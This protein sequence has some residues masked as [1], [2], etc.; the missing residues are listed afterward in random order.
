[1]AGSTELVWV[2][3]ASVGIPASVFAIFYV[4]D[5]WVRVHALN[6][7]LEYE[8]KSCQLDDQDKAELDKEAKKD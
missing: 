3:V 4:A 6:V 8:R 1:M 5:A 2:L 7:L